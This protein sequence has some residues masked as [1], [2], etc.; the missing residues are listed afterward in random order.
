M[1]PKRGGKTNPRDQYFKAIRENGVGKSMDTLRWC[2]RHG[3]VT[4]RAEDEDGATGVQI[5][6]TGGF[7]NSMEILLEFVRKAGEQK[8]LEEPD[9]NDRTPLM[10]AAYNG[11]FECVRLLVLDGKCKL[12][13]KDSAGKTAKQLAETRKQDKIVAFLADPKGWKEEE[14]DEEE[15]E[16][17]QKKRKF[18]AAQKLA[19]QATAAKAQEEVHRAKVEAQEALDRALASAAKPVWPEVEPVLRDK[20]RA[21]SIKNKPPLQLSTGPVD[22]AVW[23]CVCLFELRLEIAERALTSL[24]PQMARLVDLVTLIVTGN[25]L[26]VLPDEIGSLTKL[27]NLEAADNQLAELPPTLAQL[28]ALQVL[29]V[30]KNRL[31]SLAPLAQLEAL[32][33]AKVGF[34]ALTELPLRWEKLEHMETLAAP[35][36]ALVMAPPGLGQLQMLVTLD[37][38]ANQI[39]Q[40]PIELGNLTVKK[41]QSVKLQGNPLADPRIRRFV[42]DDSPTLVKDLLNHVR[43]NGYKG[44]AAGGGKKGG[45]KKGKKGKGKGAAVEEEDDEDADVAALLAQMAAGGDSDDAID[46]S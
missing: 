6:A 29:D 33:V 37:L 24:P 1:S 31:Q 42:E 32:T 22:P 11:K 34:N 15:D 21:L 35:N 44:E 5:A 13:S 39:E 46:V 12:D 20:Q 26:T 3:G 7:S 23:Q 2:L 30:S 17:E 9:E 19:T 14:E 28:T 41:L 43:K 27:R 10:M 4:V 38:S 16:E 45:G 25:A 36:N 18:L 40:V 8:D